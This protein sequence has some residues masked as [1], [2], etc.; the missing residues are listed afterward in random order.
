VLRAT[1]SRQRIDLEPADDPP[2]I[3]LLPAAA[4]LLW[5]RR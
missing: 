1:F 4:P 5:A 2:R 3:A